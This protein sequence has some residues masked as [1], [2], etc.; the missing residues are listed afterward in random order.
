MAM[1][2]YQNPLGQGKGCIE[3]A[4]NLVEGKAANDGTSF[5]KDDSGKDYSDSIVWIPFE[6]VTKDNVADYLECK[7][8]YL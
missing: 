3:A 1:T 8:S 7:S 6:P 5:T 4:L 2:V